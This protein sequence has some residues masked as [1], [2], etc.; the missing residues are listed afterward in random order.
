VYLLLARETGVTEA[1]SIVIHAQNLLR[2]KVSAS[3]KGLGI[4][5]FFLDLKDDIY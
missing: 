2:K 3:K 1:G 5:A 4:Y